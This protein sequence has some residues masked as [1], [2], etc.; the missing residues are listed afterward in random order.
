M[1]TIYFIFSE[2]DLHTNR[3]NNLLV[4]LLRY[5]YPL[6]LG[7]NQVKLLEEYLSFSTASQGNKRA[8]YTMLKCF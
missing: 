3:G 5:R 2:G 7:D 6:I 4:K 8:L 1:F